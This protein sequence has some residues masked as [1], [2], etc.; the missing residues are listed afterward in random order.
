[1][2]HKGDLSNGY[3]LLDSGYQSPHL[4]IQY[5]SLTA[6]DPFMHVPKSTL[7]THSSLFYPFRKKVENA[8]L[9]YVHTA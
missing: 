6:R 7:E 3:P 4:T 2:T 9:C 1:M 5:R 8:S